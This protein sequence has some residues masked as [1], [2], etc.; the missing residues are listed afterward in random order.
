MEQTNQNCQLLSAKVLA[1]ML[2]I[3]AR[4]VWRL[5]SAGKLPKPVCVGASIRWKL[6]DIILFLECDCDINKYHARKEAE[7]CQ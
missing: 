5:R 3:S 7:E 1:K 2:S 4:T 6:S